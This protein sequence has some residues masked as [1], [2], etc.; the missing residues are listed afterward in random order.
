MSTPT[1]SAD[2]NSI[3]MPVLPSI[4][5]TETLPTPVAMVEARG[6][7]SGKMNA[8]LL[9]VCCVMLMDLQ[10]ARVWGCERTEGWRMRWLCEA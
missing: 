5:A 8:W 2:V 9:C 6:L 1:A 10:N 4:E 7:E 3:H